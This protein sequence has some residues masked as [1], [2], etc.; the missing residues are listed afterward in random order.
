MNHRNDG[1]NV[2]RDLVHSSGRLAE[3]LALAHGGSLAGSIQ[4][5]TEA[6]EGRTA[7]AGEV[8][9]GRE[10]VTE[11]WLA[12]GGPRERFPPPAGLGSLRCLLLELNRYG[13]AAR[14]H[15]ARD[16][17][18]HILRELFGVVQ[19]RDAFLAR[20]A[21]TGVQ[22]ERVGGRVGDLVAAGER[23]QE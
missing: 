15:E 3:N 19:A 18:R 14:R 4:M 1:D 7:A 2:V 5:L 20:P 8:T 6:N 16:R 11:W 23:F 9:P 13:L 12:S 17:R 10:T 21:S 22:P